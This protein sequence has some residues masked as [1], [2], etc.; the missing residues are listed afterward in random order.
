MTEV[1][2]RS[3]VQMNQLTR[4]SGALY[5]HFLQPNQYV[6]GSKVLTADELRSA[7]KPESPYGSNAAEGYPMLIAAGAR[8]AEAGVRY[9]DLTRIFVNA[10]HTLYVDDCCHFGPE[11]TNALAAHIASRVA[12][13]LGSR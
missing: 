10:G 11:G 12:A 6:S 9:E 5:L 1:W 3:S 4:G 13:A 2:F 8:F 7:Y